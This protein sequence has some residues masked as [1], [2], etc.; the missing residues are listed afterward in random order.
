M[1]RG[2]EAR[3]KPPTSWHLPCARLGKNEERHGDGDWG[4]TLSVRSAEGAGGAF[5]DSVGGGCCEVDLKIWFS[6]FF[7]GAPLKCR[8]KVG[9]C[10]LL[11]LNSKWACSGW[12]LGPSGLP[13]LLLTFE[14][15]P[16][17]RARHPSLPCSFQSLSPPLRLRTCSLPTMEGL[18]FNVNNGYGNAPVPRDSWPWL[19]GDCAGTSRASFADIEMA[20]SL[21]STTATWCSVR[22]LT[23]GDTPEPP[24]ASAVAHR[25]QTSSC[26]SALPTATSSP[27]SPQTHRHPVSRRKQP[28]S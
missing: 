9:R 19:M 12:A 23:V 16:S 27:R 22:P 28:T 14:H 20:S 25:F 18:F 17:A 11:A 24:V 8:C 6:F 5:L 2:G 21:A 1:A 4:G 15:V 13:P 26:S 7:P 10:A 3:W